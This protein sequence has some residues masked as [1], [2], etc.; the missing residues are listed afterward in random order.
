MLNEN[1]DGNVI[2]DLDYLINNFQYGHLWKCNEDLLD[3]KLETLQLIDRFNN[4]KLLGNIRKQELSIVMENIASLMVDL[5]F[6]NRNITTVQM[7]MQLVGKKAIEYL[8]T[9]TYFKN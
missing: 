9:G 3:N 4:I 5:E 7:A 1:I 8:D 2:L 6:L